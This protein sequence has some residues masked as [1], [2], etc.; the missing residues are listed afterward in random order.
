MPG[1]YPLCGEKRTVESGL[2]QH[3][4]HLWKYKGAYVSVLGHLE[5]KQHQS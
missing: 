2:P 4:E 3:N 5:Q 1:E